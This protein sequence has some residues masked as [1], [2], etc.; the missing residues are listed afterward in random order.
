[1]DEAARGRESRQRDEE[2]EHLSKLSA[3][4]F[5]RRSDEFDQRQNVKL[6]QI[7]K[8][9]QQTRTVI[10]SSQCDLSFLRL[11]PNDSLRKFEELEHEKNMDRSPSQRCR[12]TLV[13]INAWCVNSPA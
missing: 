1:M 11:D 9:Y 7:L 5:R 4:S 13:K 2:N 10:N 3:A 6:K 8:S 12:G